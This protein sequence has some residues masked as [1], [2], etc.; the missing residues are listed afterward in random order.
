MTYSGAMYDYGK[1]GTVEG[2]TDYEGAVI[3]F[4]ASKS[5]SIYKDIST[6]QVAAIQILIIIKD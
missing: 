5:N 2:G 4:M 3:G 1:Y 6:V